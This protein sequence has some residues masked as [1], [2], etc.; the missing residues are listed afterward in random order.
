MLIIIL[1][2]WWIGIYNKINTRRILKNHLFLQNHV[3]VKT[4]YLL[5]HSTEEV[6]GQMAADG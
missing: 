6:Q 5:Q 2:L 4:V 3:I 1:A